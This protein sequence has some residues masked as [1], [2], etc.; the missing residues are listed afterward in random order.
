MVCID[1][2]ISK[3]KFLELPL[4]IATIIVSPTALDTPSTREAMIPDSAAGKT[5]LSVVSSLVEPSARAPSRSVSGTELI[6]SSD[7]DVTMGM[8]MIPM[9]IPGLRAFFAPSEGISLVNMGVTKE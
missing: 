3:V 6:A 5:T 8:I 2:V 7:S 9:T 4:A 1:C